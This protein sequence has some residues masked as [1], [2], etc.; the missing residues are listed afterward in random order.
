MLAVSDTGV[1]MDAETQARIFEPFFT[2]KEPGKGTGL[3]LA[4]VYGIVKQSGGHI[5]VDERARPR[6]DA[7]RIYLP[8]AQ[9]GRRA[10]RRRA[11]RAGGRLARQRDHAAGRGRRRGARARRARCCERTATTCSRRRDGADAL[12]IAQRTT[13]RIDLLLTD[14]VMPEMTAASWPSGC[15]ST[16]PELRV[17]FMSGYTPDVTLLEG[18]PGADFIMK[19]FRPAQLTTKLRALPRLTTTRSADNR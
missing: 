15:A 4:T 18:L 10:E 8:R 11:R 17:L 13:G 1:G 2:T 12:R 9:P 14:V 5:W 3:G 7:S 16:R 6:H 19:P